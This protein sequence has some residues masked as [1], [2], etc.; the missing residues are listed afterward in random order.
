LAVPTG[1]VSHPVVQVHSPEKAE[2]HG[3]RALHAR[4]T[5]HGLGLG[6]ASPGSR[7]DNAGAKAGVGT[8]REA[9]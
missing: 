9:F 1:V 8:T 4:S 6:G 5:G 2:M 7:N 3:N